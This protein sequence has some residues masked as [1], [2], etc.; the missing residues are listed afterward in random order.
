MSKPPVHG[1]HQAIMRPQPPKPVSDA[2]RASDANQAAHQTYRDQAQVNSHNLNISG[3][4][5][6][7]ITKA[8]LDRAKAAEK[9]MDAHAEANKKLSDYNKSLRDKN[10]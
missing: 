10:K 1:P 7:S 4:Q 6:G 3:H 8:L 9:A 2:Q 5:D